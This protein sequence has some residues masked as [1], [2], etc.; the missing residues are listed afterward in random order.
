MVLF[1]RASGTGWRDRLGPGLHPGL[2]TGLGGGEMS[3]V[4]REGNG[5]RTSGAP[6]L[7]PVLC[8]GDDAG[9]VGVVPLL[10]LSDADELIPT[11]ATTISLI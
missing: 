8:T 2:C 10:S 9:E 7:R 6:G 11:I 1:L 5:K 4:P 3:V